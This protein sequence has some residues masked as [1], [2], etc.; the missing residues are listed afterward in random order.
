MDARAIKTIFVRKILEYKGQA[1]FEFILF[2]PVFITMVILLIRLS[3]ALNGAINQQKV[4]RGYFYARVKGNSLVPMAEDLAEFGRGG[5]SQAGMFMIGWKDYFLNQGEPM[6]PCY[7]FKTVLW[8]SDE[9]CE[10]TQKSG[11]SYFVKI[12]TGY[13][14]CGTTYQIAGGNRKKDTGVNSSDCTV[15]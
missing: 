14:V 7:N 13:G 9:R 8:N 10:E 15:Q 1:L 5:V 12:K 4:T 2:F 6:A 3:S 11:K